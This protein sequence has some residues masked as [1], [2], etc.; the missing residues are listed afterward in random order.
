MKVTDQTVIVE[1]TFNTS[2]ENIWKAITNLDEMKQW[3]F[4]TIPNFKPAVGFKTEFNVNSGTRDFMHVWKI[5]EVIPAKKITYDWSYKKYK[6]RGL[7]TFELCNKNNQTKLVL[8]N[9]VIE[10]FPDEIPEFKRE[11]CVGGWKFFINQNLKD[12]IQKKYSK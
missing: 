11:S 8:T 2:K 7:V 3:F 10:D 4:N 12:Y 6:G 5:I 9:M 1:E